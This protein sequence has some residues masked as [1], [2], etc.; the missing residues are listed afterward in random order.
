MSTLRSL[1]LLGGGPIGDAVAQAAL[2]SADHTV[3]VDTESVDDVLAAQ[4]DCVVA[5]GAASAADV[6]TLL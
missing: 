6:V 1:A 4:A 3:V 2:R 5:T